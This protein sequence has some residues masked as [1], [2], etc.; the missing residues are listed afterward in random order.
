MYHRSALENKARASQR[1]ANESELVCSLAAVR[2]PEAE[3]LHD[4]G[5]RFALENA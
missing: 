3:V 4:D 1:A 5:R 2:W